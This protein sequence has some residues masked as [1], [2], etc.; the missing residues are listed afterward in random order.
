MARID[1]LRISWAVVLAAALMTG[2]G[3]RQEKADIYIEGKTV[4][5][6][7]TSDVSLPT[8]GPEMKVVTGEPAITI[9]D[10]GTDGTTAED[11]QG[12][13]AFKVEQ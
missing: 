8:E 3:C 10:K 1:H 5:A 6:I 9:D 12:A 13:V 4:D 11:Q 7:K 2:P